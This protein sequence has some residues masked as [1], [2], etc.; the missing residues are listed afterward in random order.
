MEAVLVAESSGRV[1]GGQQ[2]KQKEG[3]EQTRGLPSLEQVAQRLGS[4]DY[5]AYDIE[6]IDVLAKL[7]L[8]MQEAGQ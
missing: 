8:E 3:K 1:S 2:A 4:H 5:K 7:M 6:K